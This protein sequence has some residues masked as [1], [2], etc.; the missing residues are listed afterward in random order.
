MNK[1]KFLFLAILFV[2]VG[3]IS[4]IGTY[5][6][7]K[8]TAS[9]TATIS[10]ASFEL[11]VNGSEISRSTQTFPL[12]G[13][14]WTNSL[15]TQVATGKIAPGSTATLPLTIDVTGSSID[16][17]YMVKVE[18]FEGLTAVIDGTAGLT[19]T[20]TITYSEQ[21]NAMRKQMNVVLTWSGNLNDIDTKNS[22]DVNLKNRHETIT[23]I[24]IAY[25][26]LSSTP[27]I[28]FPR[29]Y[30][31]GEVVYFDPTS[32]E[33]VC[34]T[35]NH[36]AETCMTWRVIGSDTY[37]VNLQ[38]DHNLVNKVAWDTSGSNNDG[39]VTVLNSLKDATSTWDNVEPL[40]YTYDTSASAQNYGT[41][42][43]TNGACTISKTGAEIGANP[44]L[45]ENG[46]PVRARL[47]TGEEVA[48][49]TRTQTDGTTI[50]DSFT[51]GNQNWF[52]FSE[53]TKL[54]GTQDNGTGNIYLSW[55]IENTYTNNNSGAIANTYGNVNSGYW[56]LSPRSTAANTILYVYA[57]GSL[58]SNVHVEN[59]S[60]YGARP[61]ITIP[62]SK[63]K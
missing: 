31:Y 11:S 17:D 46:I 6:I 37:N 38:L 48:A 43:C 14:T 63:I 15:G 1:K 21:A 40:T 2:V 41:L 26:H 34:T 32:D 56:T 53:S 29:S 25:Q 19:K 3:S 12:S 54:I 61:V 49:I 23:I 4:S 22:T 18:G 13:L 10:T 55:L 58:Y 45:V 36:A 52:Y 16:V 42:S 39:P 30:S 24:V 57:G 44:E 33:T 59:D 7:Y 47:I 20:G 8:L 5:A 60:L 28:T 35:S 27:T 51:L 62:K 9:G 50:A